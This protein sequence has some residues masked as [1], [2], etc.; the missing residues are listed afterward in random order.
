MCALALAV[1]DCLPHLLVREWAGVNLTTH[2]LVAPGVDIQ[3][4]YLFPAA[5]LPLCSLPLTP[6]CTSPTPQT[7]GHYKGEGTNTDVENTGDAVKDKA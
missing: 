4:S 2:E 1:C 6:P 5:P 7:P 3:L